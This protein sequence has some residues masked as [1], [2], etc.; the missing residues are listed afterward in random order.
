MGQFGYHFGTN[1]NIS[2]SKRRE[3]IFRSENIENLPD[4]SF[5]LIDN[6]NSCI[7]EGRII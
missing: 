2:T 3:P 4:D 6:F 1:T 5:I 7:G